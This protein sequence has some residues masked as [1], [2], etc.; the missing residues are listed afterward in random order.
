MFCKKV[1]LKI[2]Q[3]SHEKNSFL[4]KFYWKETPTQLFSRENF[5]NTYFEE[6]LR[7]TASRSITM[8]QMSSIFTTDNNTI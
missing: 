7:T 6:H 4:N 3:I 5:K 8:Q 2:S 1:F